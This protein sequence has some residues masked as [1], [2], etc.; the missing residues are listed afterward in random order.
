MRGGADEDVSETHR[1]NKLKKTCI[2]SVYTVL[3]YTTLVMFTL[4]CYF[5]V[6]IYFK[7]HNNS[8]CKQI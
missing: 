2:T 6:D 7:Y 8:N 5:S 4:L 1:T 3:Y